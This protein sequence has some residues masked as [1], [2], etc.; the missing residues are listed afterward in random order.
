[1]GQVLLVAK[2]MA[3]D[4]HWKSIRNLFSEHEKLV[5]VVEHC[6]I[7]CFQMLCRVK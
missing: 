7:E 1:M 4:F 3:C 6:Q 5:I 2:A